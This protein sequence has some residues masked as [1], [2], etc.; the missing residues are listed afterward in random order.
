MYKLKPPTNKKWQVEKVS[1]YICDANHKAL[2]GI[3]WKSEKSK[4][5]YEYAHGTVNTTCLSMLDEILRLCR[6]QSVGTL[7]IDDGNYENFLRER[8]RSSARKLF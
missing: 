7:V 8:E 5:F 3:L 1:C 2:I 6:A 4:F